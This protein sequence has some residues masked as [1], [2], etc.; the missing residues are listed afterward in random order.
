MDVDSKMYYFVNICKDEKLLDERYVYHRT[1]RSDQIPPAVTKALDEKLHGEPGV[2]KFETRF[3][4]R[5]P[6][7]DMLKYNTTPITIIALR[8]GMEEEN[9]LNVTLPIPGT[10][11]WGPDEHRICRRQAV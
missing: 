4:Q 11:D 1:K 5:T 8:D 3:N 7:W 2:I 9:N 10:A 6:T